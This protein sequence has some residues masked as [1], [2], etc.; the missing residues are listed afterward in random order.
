MPAHKVP[1]KIDQGATFDQTYTW[2][3]GPPTSAVPVDLTGCTARSQV[4]ADLQDNQV[5]LELTTEN[6]RIELGGA[7]GTIRLHLSAADTAAI[8]REAG[9]YD[10]EI[11]FPGGR[12]VRRMAGT[13]SVSPEQ[14]RARRQVGTTR[15]GGY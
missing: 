5:L 14:T 11:E 9:V 15:Y 13:V 7:S 6:D 10:L 2:K 1:L 3:A 4:R 8:A 12:V